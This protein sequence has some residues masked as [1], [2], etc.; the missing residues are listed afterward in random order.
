MLK[1]CPAGP[2]SLQLER[3]RALLVRACGVSVKQ[4]QLAA[5]RSG[6]D[7]ARL[8]PPRSKPDQWGE[9]HCPFSVV[10]TFEAHDPINAAAALRELELR[11]KVSGAARAS[12]PLFHDAR[13]EP[14]THHFLHRM[15]RAVLA[16]CYG[17]AA[18]S[19]Y[20][21]HSYRSG[22]AT[23][24]HA[25]GVDDPMIQLI[26]R[27]MCPESLHVYRRMGV[28]E[29][30]RLI[31]RASQTDVDLIQST[32]APRVFADQGFAE[33]SGEFAESRSA[34]AQAAYEAAVNAALDPFRRETRPLQT[35]G[36]EPAEPRIPAKRKRAA[37]EAQL[38]GGIEA[39]TE[40]P[41]TPGE[42]VDEQL[43]IGTEVAVLRET[44]PKYACSE[45]GG[46]AWHATVVARA[47]GRA[48]V[49]FTQARSKDGRRY[50]NSCLALQALR[51]V[52]RGDGQ[53]ATGS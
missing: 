32:N 5:M 20:S 25:A 50:E 36:R 14:Y 9:I 2:D 18:A 33:L 26:C 1:C 53:T 17:T 39:P 10:L 16:H 12:T 21:W 52:T 30:E 43:Q 47:A 31:K 40:P 37:G 19:L 22:L 8:A 29:H 34:T 23:A 7:G 46:R 49:R 24:L 35:E 15:L 45:M 48:T 28:A 38:T 11:C 6:I 42:P 3:W 4:A 44:W 13:G 51:L 41:Q 27:W